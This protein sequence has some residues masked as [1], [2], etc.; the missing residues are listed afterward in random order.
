MREY[1]W[2]LTVW[3]Y[4]CWV[5]TELSHQSDTLSFC[6]CFGLIIG[7]VASHHHKS[8][9]SRES[10]CIFSFYLLYSRWTSKYEYLRGVT[11]LAAAVLRTELLVSVGNF[12]GKR[13]SVIK[14]NRALSGQIRITNYGLASLKWCQ[15]TFVTCKTS[16]WSAQQT[17][18]WAKKMLKNFCKNHKIVT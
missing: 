18:A 12:K 1:L 16:T 5:T 6:A 8:L 17:F 10:V 4:Y 14:E 15:Q 7:I 11:M 9:V 13:C 2:L 3:F